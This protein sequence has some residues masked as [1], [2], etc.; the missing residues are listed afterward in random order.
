MKY[1]L[2]I[3]IF[4]C[5][6]APEPTDGILWRTTGE[7]QKTHNTISLGFVKTPVQLMF[8][9][10]DGQIVSFGKI[11]IDSIEIFCDGKLVAAGGSFRKHLEQIESAYQ[12]AFL[13]PKDCHYLVEIKNSSFTSLT[14]RV[15][16]ID[17]FIAFEYQRSTVNMVLLGCVGMLLFCSILF[18][19]I[20]RWPIAIPV[21]L[22]YASSLVNGSVFSIHMDAKLAL[23]SFNTSALLVSLSCALTYRMLSNSVIAKTVVKVCVVAFF[24]TLTAQ[25]FDLNVNNFVTFVSGIISFAAVGVAVIRNVR[26]DNLPLFGLSFGLSCTSALVY[27]ALAGGFL[28]VK[29]E[30]AQV[31]LSIGVVSAG[32]ILGAS[33]IQKFLNMLHLKEREKRENLG[34][35][36]VKIA[37]RV[38]SPLSIIQFQVEEIQDATSDMEEQTESILLQVNRVKDAVGELRRFRQYAPADALK[39]DVNVE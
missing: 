23:Q 6:C 32:L 7:W 21:I 16:D 2:L 24:A 29:N 15:Y 35:V 10:Q 1:L 5:S 34:I 38:N 27:L 8:D 14:P 30:D 9:G 17:K 18:Y 13:L 19:I 20:F 28:P 4:L 3:F 31:F 36:A 11:Y 22:Y 12:P 25:V 37:D 33:I 26:S 39:K